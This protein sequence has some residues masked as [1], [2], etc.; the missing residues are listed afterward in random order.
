MPEYTV[1]YFA[2]FRE[3]AG[4]DCETVDSNAQTGRDLY[5]EL[6]AKHS[7]PLDYGIVKLAIGGQFADLDDQLAPGAE[8]LFI[9]PVAGG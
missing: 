1:R 7:F 5:T 9:P 4:T 8:V 3:L 2:L 6:K